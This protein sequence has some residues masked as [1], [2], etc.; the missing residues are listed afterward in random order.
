M[1]ERRSSTS[2]IA[3]SCS[4]SGGVVVNSVRMAVRPECVSGIVAPFCAGQGRP[5]HLR[6]ALRVNLASLGWSSWTRLTVRCRRDWH[7]FVENELGGR[8]QLHFLQQLGEA[9]LAR[10]PPAGNLCHDTGEREFWQVQT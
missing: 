10:L 4:G 9:T 5:A 6:L 3:C 2:A 1:T 7:D 8:F